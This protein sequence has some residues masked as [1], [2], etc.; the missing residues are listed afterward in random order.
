MAYRALVRP[1]CT[2]AILRF[3]QRVEGLDH[4][5]RSMNE[6]HVDDSNETVMVDVV[7][8]DPLIRIRSAYPAMQ[9]EL[10]MI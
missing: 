8:D 1:A 3:Q 2:P 4:V 9:Y 5:E 10:H 7:W 6:Y